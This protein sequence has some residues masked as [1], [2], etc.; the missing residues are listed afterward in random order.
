MANILYHV[1]A[2][3]GRFN[4]GSEAMNNTMAKFLAKKGHTVHILTNPTMANEG[5]TRDGLLFFTD[6][7]NKD[8]ID[9]Q[10][11]WAD[12]VVTSIAFTPRVI[13]LC[14]KHNKR[15]IYVIHNNHSVPYWDVKP[16]DVWMAVYNADWIRKH[17]NEQFKWVPKQEITL[18][19]PVMYNEYQCEDEGKEYITLVNLCENK[20]ILTLIMAAKMLP[21][22]K[23]LGVTGAYAEQVLV[24]LPKNV[25]VI[26]HT[27]DMVEN[28]YSKSKIIIMPSLKETWGM[29]AIE[30]MCSGIPCV[31]HPTEGLAEACGDAGVFCVRDKAYLW[32][33]ILIKL[34]ENEE[35]YKAV[36]DKCRERALFL[37]IQAESQLNSWEQIIREN[38]SV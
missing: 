31:A 15:L 7:L 13:E 32:Q 21:Q 5:E 2:W 35:Y 11:K 33:G 3:S 4:A 9:D 26:S 30:G 18:Y 38:A 29:V 24:G 6:I 37:S 17:H 10:Y 28:V 34:M 19:P 23:F 20:G 16:D 8:Y 36:S 14:K 27:K 12:F 22:Y 1:D 25:T